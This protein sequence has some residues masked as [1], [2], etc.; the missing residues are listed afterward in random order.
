MNLKNPGGLSD[1]I[2]FFEYTKAANPLAK[3]TIIDV[4]PSLKEGDSG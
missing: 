2:R 3:G 1:D 4:L